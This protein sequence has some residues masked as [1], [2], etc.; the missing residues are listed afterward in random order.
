MNTNAGT[1]CTLPPYQCP[2]QRCSENGDW[3][4]ISGG[5]VLWQWNC[6]VTYHT[7]VHTEAAMRNWINGCL[8]LLH[9]LNWSV[10]VIGP[11]TIRR[12]GSWRTV[13]NSKR[14]AWTN[15][16]EHTHFC[17]VVCMYKCVCV[18]V[19]REWKEKIEQSNNRTVPFPAARWCAICSAN[20]NSSTISLC[21]M[22][23][24]EGAYWDHRSLW[25]E[26]SD[27]L[28]PALMQFPLTITGFGFS[29]GCR[30]LSAVTSSGDHLEHGGLTRTQQTHTQANI[31]SNKPPNNA[32]GNHGHWSNSAS[33]RVARRTF[34]VLNRFTDPPGRACQRIGHTTELWYT[35]NTILHLNVFC[36]FVAV[37][38]STAHHLL[39]H[40]AQPRKV[41]SS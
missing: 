39:T 14:T 2:E 30:F 34:A 3:R 40:T 23:H 12:S 20:S 13:G 41:R 11:G 27:P 22:R 24:F 4:C 1:E 9:F 16:L 28:N 6:S 38:H 15:V 33:L 17:R 37:Q 31:R 26:S 29:F 19:K 7:D 21:M 25:L 36:C 8:R 10:R 32:R 5:W 35:G 18:C